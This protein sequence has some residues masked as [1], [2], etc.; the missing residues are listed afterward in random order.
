[1]FHILIL[2][3]GVAFLQTVTRG[4]KNKSIPGLQVMLL[5]KRVGLRQSYY[6]YQAEPDGLTVSTERFFAPLPMV[7][8]HLEFVRADTT[9]DI[10]ESSIILVMYLSKYRIT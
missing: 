5:K 7:V 10:P 3:V 6:P 1:M 8:R 4:S 2:S 9:S